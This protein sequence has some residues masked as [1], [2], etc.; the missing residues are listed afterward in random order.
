MLESKIGRMVRNTLAGG[1]LSLP[2]IAHKVA[3]SISGI[4]FTYPHPHGADHLVGT[5]ASDIALTGDTPRLYEALLE[6]AYV[7]VTSTP[8][9]LDG[10]AEH[11]RVAVP[12]DPAQRPILVRPDGYIAWAGEPGTVDL[13]AALTD[14]V[15]TA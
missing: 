12:A 4:G 1:A 8:V 11:V 7:L 2:P 6:G 9:T 14:W 13:D 5:R 3:G 10:Q 15:R